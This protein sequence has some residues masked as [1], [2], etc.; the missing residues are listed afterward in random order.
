MEPR[1]EGEVTLAPEA[2]SFEG[3]LLRVQLIEATY[4]DAPSRTVAES[5]IEGV[6]HRRGTG[7]R[8]PF[9]LA[10]GKLDPHARYLATAHISRTGSREIA[11]GDFHSTQ[12]HPVQEGDS[13][14]VVPVRVVG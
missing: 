9:S 8:W 4:A 3:G 14:L 11:A 12:S 2:P 7:S 5:F 6:S 13:H 1:I 10:A